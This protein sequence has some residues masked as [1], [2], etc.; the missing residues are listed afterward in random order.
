MDS[1]SLSRDV[2]NTIQ[3]DKNTSARRN[4]PKTGETK[5]AARDVPAARIR[6]ICAAVQTGRTAKILHLVTGF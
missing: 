1:I 2:Y 5:I 6:A 3:Y 4:R